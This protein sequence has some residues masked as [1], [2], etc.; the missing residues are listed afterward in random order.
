[1]VDDSRPGLEMAAKCKVPFAAA[2][3]SPKTPA[4]K[5]WMQDHADFYFDQVEKLAEFIL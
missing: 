5:R 1:M 4:I 3:W 2:G